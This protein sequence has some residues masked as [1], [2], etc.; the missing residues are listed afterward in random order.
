LLER[1]HTIAAIATAH[2][3]A[4]LGII[5]LS[6]PKAAEIIDQ[7][8]PG[9]RPSRRPRRVLSGIAKHPRDGGSIDRVLCFFCPGPHTA[10]GEDTAEIHGHGGLFVLK[11]LLGA[12]LE[13]GA[14]IAEPGEFTYR[15][16][17]NGKID[18][19]QAEAVMGLIGAQ[20][21]RA[22]AVAFNQ[23]KGSLGKSL[24]GEFEELTKIAAH[25]E[26]SLDFPDEDLP[27]EASRQIA[28]SLEG[29]YQ[30]L[31]RVRDSY[32]LGSRLAHGA[33]VA[34]VG[35]PN[36]GKS[37]LLNR[38][39]G[40]EKALV[41]SEPGTTRDVVEAESQ[42]MGIPLTFLDTAGLRGS[43]NRVEKLGMK[44][45]LEAARSADAII[46][47][48]D[49][50]SDHYWPTEFE[51]LSLPRERTI[52]VLNKKDLPGWKSCDQLVSGMEPLEQL[53]VS[54][55]TG[56][57]VEN[58]ALCLSKMIGEADRGES[59]V[60]TTARQH[61]VVTE[62]AAHVAEAAEIL[63]QGL[64]PELSATELMW[65]REKL[66][67]LFGRSATEEMLDTI[68]SQFCIGK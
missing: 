7:V 67:A 52:V 55:L 38:L 15:A 41:D 24:D 20:S 60:L 12:A 53:G 39:I 28:S 11:T 54:A 63:R 40:D 58:I 22:A 57:G 56:E 4:A 23:L 65:A 6:G 17:R 18:L 9:V 1:E 37:S 36:A 46:V 42:V 29:I 66:A 59:S 31:S 51:N 64:A 14:K 21:E 10:T 62:A 68:F 16:F 43:E 19:T 32:R 50:A 25:V 8:V 13:A 26:A 33:K 44:K 45:S 30:R 3:P 48:L 27:L 34:I 47:V 49:G 35:P 2:G 61:A 5:R